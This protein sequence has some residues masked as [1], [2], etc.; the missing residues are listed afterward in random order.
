MTVVT[1]LDGIQNQTAI[2]RATMDAALAKSHAALAESARLERRRPGPTA[3]WEPCA[4]FVVIEGRGRVRC[5]RPPEPSGR[6]FCWE[7]SAGDADRSNPGAD[8]T[9]RTQTAAS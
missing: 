7:H 6:G 8:G 1:I 4:A 9:S 3:S 5:W 2:T